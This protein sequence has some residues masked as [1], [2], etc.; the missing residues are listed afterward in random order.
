MDRWLLTQAVLREPTAA[1]GE[2]WTRSGNRA[3]GLMLNLIQ[4]LR[5]NICDCRLDPA[6]NR[7]VST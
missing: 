1:P 5:G 4:S 2:R 7:V 6:F 3:T